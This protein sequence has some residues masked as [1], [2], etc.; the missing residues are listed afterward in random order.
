[1]RAE[2]DGLR[3]CGLRVEPGPYVGIAECYSV[4]AVRRD[5]ER[6]FTASLVPDCIVFSEVWD[7]NVKM[8]QSGVLEGSV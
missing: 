4:E 7:V 5:L 6:P 3:S 1:V 8:Y 2:E